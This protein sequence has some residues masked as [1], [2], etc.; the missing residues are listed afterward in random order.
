MASGVMTEAILIIASIVVATSVAGIVM[1]KV[2]SFES[3]FTATSES[4]KNIM[5]TKLAIPYAIQNATSTTIIEVWVK[6]VGIDPVT[7][8][9]S[10]DVYFGPI[11]SLKR[12]QYDTS[13]TDDTWKFKTLPTIIQKSDAV[14]IRITETSLSAGTYMVRVT[15]PNGVYSDYIFSIS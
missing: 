2:G 3:T 1:S 4:Q 7:N 6:N 13:A 11:D 12:Y 8:P 14:Q 10:M 15:A 9:T 5:L